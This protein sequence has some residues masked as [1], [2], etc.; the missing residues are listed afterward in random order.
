MEKYLD[1]NLKIKLCEKGL[2]WLKEFLRTTEKIMITF[3]VKK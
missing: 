3:L 1:F 2:N